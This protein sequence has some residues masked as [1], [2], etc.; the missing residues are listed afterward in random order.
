MRSF[1]IRR[2]IAADLPALKQVL[3]RTGLFP[4]ELLDGMIAP[5]LAG[6]T[7]A[8]WL[9]CHADG[10]PVGLCFTAPKEMP[11]RTWNLLAIGVEPDR[12][13]RGIGAA[14]VRA[15]EAELRQQEQ[16][17]L[18][19]DTSGRPEFGGVH[20]FYKALRYTQ[21]ARIPDFWAAGDDKL[22]FCKRL[23]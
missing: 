23:F 14:L 19:I 22:V 21:A 2:S 10:Q 4:S 20:R 16:R 5:A 1:D 7:E 12:R 3:D 13:R 17:L 6:E 9:T 18:L 15:V 8:F 11:D